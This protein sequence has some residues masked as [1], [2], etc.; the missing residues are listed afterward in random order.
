[1]ATRDL[2]ARHAV[3]VTEPKET[4]ELTPT[5]LVAGGDALGRDDDGRVVFVAGA[6]PG[7]RVLVAPGETR[8][9]FT[10]A[11]LIEVLDPS[12]D[13]VEPPCPHVARGCGGCPW[14]HIDVAAQRVHRGEIIVD[15]LRR[16]ARIPDPPVGPPVELPSAGYRTS[17]RLLSEGGRPAYR[18]AGSHEPVTIDSC[19]VL[20]PLLAD[21]L[22]T[23]GFAG[24]REVELRAG[25][26]TG[27]RLVVAHP[28][29]SRLRLPQGVTSVS[30]AEVRRGRRVCYHEEVAGRRW[31]ISAGSFFQVRPDGADVLA[32]LVLAAASDASR[33][34]DLYAGVGLFAGVLGAVGKRVVAVE[35][36][37]IAA[38]DARRNLADVDARIVVSDVARYKAV[39][40]DVVVADPSRAGLRAEGVAAALAAEPARLV[41]VSCDAAA[42]ARDAVLLAAE[43]YELVS[44]T[45]V[46]MFPHTAHVECVSIFDLSRK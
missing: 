28:K 38:E 9:D 13:R 11:D 34:T 14:Q 21:M 36:H 10:R 18:R 29:A 5:A 20:H 33:V 8:R 3:V 27:E 15:A 25:A 19:L 2:P 40:A 43:S 35:A 22:T 31:Q 26:R 24:A 16:I 39:P 23:A 1:M 30:T 12:P 4:I 46:D 6:L 17:V 37:R 44:V 32:D 42:L 41:V 45:P 7:E